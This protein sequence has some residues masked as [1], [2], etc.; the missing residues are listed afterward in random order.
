MSL[1]KLLWL[2]LLATGLAAPAF[3]I[4]VDE[5]T[6]GDFDTN[7]NFSQTT[8]D[9][10]ILGGSRH[11][12]FVHSGGSNFGLYLSLYSFYNGGVM[13]YSGF[14]NQTTMWRLTYGGSASDAN[15]LNLSYCGATSLQVE[16]G[17]QLD[18]NCSGDGVDGV[19][20][21]VNVVSGANSASV[22]HMVHCAGYGDQGIVLEDFMFS[23]FPGINFAAVDQLSFTFNQTPVNS[24]V[25]YFVNGI[26]TVCDDGFVVGADDQPTAFQLGEAFP[27][28]FNPT[29][30]LEYSLAET[31]A[32]SLKVFDL[33]GREV[34]TLV[35]GLTE[36]GTHRVTFDAGTLPSGVYFYTLQAAGQTQTRKMLLVK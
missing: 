23:E 16:L 26:N 21:T 20:I 28:P 6:V 13:S 12:E 25:D 36:R 8:L 19:P 5:F 17:G 33:S 9:A 10:S 24:P 22:T 1:R 11:V 14:F 4:V 35:N 3:A 30:T 2:P 15:R 7:V 32:A 18:Y 34:A 27:N 31:G 29:T